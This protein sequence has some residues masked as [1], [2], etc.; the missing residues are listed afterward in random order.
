MFM[1]ILLCAALIIG[2][3][4]AYTQL[5][6]S[7]AQKLKECNENVSKIYDAGRQAI[8]KNGNGY[9]ADEQTGYYNASDNG[10]AKDLAGCQQL[11]GK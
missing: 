11:Y 4:Y 10:Y 6:K 7:T 2:G 5:T 3:Y 9:S 1:K 8:A